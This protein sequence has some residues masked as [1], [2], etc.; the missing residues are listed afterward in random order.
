MPP[1]SNQVSSIKNPH[2]P[3]FGIHVLYNTIFTPNFNEPLLTCILHVVARVHLSLTHRLHPIVGISVA[4]SPTPFLL[5]TSSLKDS[6]KVSLHSLK[7]TVSIN[8]CSCH[9]TLII[10]RVICSQIHKQKILIILASH[11]PEFPL[12]SLI[13]LLHSLVSPRHCTSI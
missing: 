6:L 11:Q 8:R 3:Y 4:P 12:Y 2:L 10:I 7:A 13:T 5:V 1:I 9:T